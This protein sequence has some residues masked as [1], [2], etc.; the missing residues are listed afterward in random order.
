MVV[1]LTKDTCNIGHSPQ[2]T[3]VIVFAH[4]TRGPHAQT[5]HT[6][7]AVVVVRWAPR[8]LYELDT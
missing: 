6:S 3:V 1:Y 8:D 5:F 4:G 7:A 2:Y